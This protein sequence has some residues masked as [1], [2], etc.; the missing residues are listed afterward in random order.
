[1]FNTK[2][3]KSLM[4]LALA[5]LSLSAHAHRGW[6]VPSSTMVESKDAWVTVDAAVSDGLFEIDHQPL[7][8]DLLQITG[9]DGATVAPANVLTGRL[10]SVF[11]VKLEKPGTYK[12]AIVSQ[13]VMAS[14]K[15]NGEQKRFRGNEETFKKDVPA[16]AQELKVTR[17]AGRLETFFSNGETSTVVF[18]PTGAGLEFVPVTHPNDLRAG[19]KA[20]WRFLVDGKPAANLAFSLVPGGVRYRGVLG[21]IRQTTDAKGEITFTVPAAGMYYLSSSW[22]AAAP[23][24]PGQPPAMPERRMTY[25]ASV[26]VLPQ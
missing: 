9:P 15:V 7:R 13:T 2:V 25:A 21:E 20:T 5:G 6:M 17:T 26:E 11:D 24:V 10:R 8:L 3:R 12:A 1:M 4:V 22:P 14:Y 23:S 19:E 18:K 16:D